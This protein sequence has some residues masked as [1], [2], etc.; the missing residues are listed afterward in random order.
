M[1]AVLVVARGHEGKLVRDLKPEDVTVLDNGRPARV[2]VLEPAPKPPLRIGILLAG[3]ESTFKTQQAAA[4]HVLESLRPGDQAFVV[5]QAIATNP[6]PWSNKKLNWESDPKV[7][8]AFVAGLRWN[9]GLPSTK[10]LVMGMLA[11]NPDKPF[12]RL[13]LEF[14]DPELETSVPYRTMSAEAFAEIDTLE[15]AEY[16]RRRAIVYATTL[17]SLRPLQYD[18]QPAS[19][20]VERLSVV[21]GGRYLPWDDIESEVAGIRED[22]DNQMLLM[23]EAQSGDPQRPQRLEIRVAR[24]DIHLAYPKEFYPLTPPAN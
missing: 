15:I 5:T 3:D 9:Q 18:F 13:M 24:K 11:L 16:Q 23:F 1:G 22:L 4:I 21:T 19:V 10:D 8:K 20:K 17:K 2:T 6:R 14:R 12:R 7:L